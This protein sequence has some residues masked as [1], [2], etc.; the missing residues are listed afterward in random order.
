MEQEKK[1][2]AEKRGKENEDE[3]TLRLEKDKKRKTE[4][5]KYETAADRSSRND[6]EKKRAKNI[7]ERPKS[8]HEGR[9]AQ[10]IL[11]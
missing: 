3:T 1:R 9:N 7:R 8:L 5:R 6:K 10:N 2:I 4:K 11:N